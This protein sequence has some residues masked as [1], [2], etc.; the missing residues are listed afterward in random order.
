MSA[1][2]LPQECL[3]PPHSI[4]LQASAQQ[5][6]T[7]KSEQTRSQ[8]NCQHRYRNNLSSPLALGCGRGYGRRC[9]RR[10][11]VGCRRRNGRSSGCRRGCRR[12]DGRGRGR[13]YERRRSG[14]R[15]TITHGGSK[16]GR[17]R[18][19]NWGRNRGRNRRRNRGKNRSKWSNWSDWRLRGWLQR[20]SPHLAA[21]ATAIEETEI[22]S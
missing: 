3:V 18:G 16:R 5:R 15:H 19:R 1:V 22:S 4:E 14:R 2:Q 17:N 6:L 7:K 21:F 10:Y 11:G 9:R 20:R 13:R 8:F 12:R